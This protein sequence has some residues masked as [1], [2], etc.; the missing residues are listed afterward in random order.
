VPRQGEDARR[1][2]ADVTHSSKFRAV[3]TIIKLYVC[4][5]VCVRAF[6]SPPALLC[7]I[8]ISVCDD[9]CE[10]EKSCIHAE[11]VP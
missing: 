3:A 6:N 2:P 1:V 5:C 11:G 4:M 10:D 8:F 7:F 9:A